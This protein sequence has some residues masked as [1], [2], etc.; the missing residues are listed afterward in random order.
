MLIIL[1][2]S[3]QKLNFATLS[4]QFEYFVSCCYI[5]ANVLLHYF[6]VLE[7]MMHLMDHD[8]INEELAKLK[9]T[10]GLDI[11]LSYDGLRVPVTL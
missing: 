3:T 8:I 11:E 6:R 5:F 4:S 1:Y 9:D 2:G 7:G 10:E